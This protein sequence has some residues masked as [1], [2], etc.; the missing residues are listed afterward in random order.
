MIP[1]K[2]SINT[3]KPNMQENTKNLKLKDRDSTEKHTLEVFNYGKIIIHFARF[4]D[5]KSTIFHF[6]IQ[7]ILS[8]SVLVIILK[9]LI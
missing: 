6:I 9:N 3:A 1:I 8:V 7:G 2:R 4:I 5:I